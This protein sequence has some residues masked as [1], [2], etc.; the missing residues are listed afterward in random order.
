[1]TSDKN[2]LWSRQTDIGID[3]EIDIGINL[4]TDSSFQRLFAVGGGDVGYGGGRFGGGDEL[5]TEVTESRPESTKSLGSR[6]GTR[7]QRQKNDDGDPGKCERNI[8]ANLEQI[9]RRT[10]GWNRRSTTER[11]RNNSE[12]PKSEGQSNKDST[13]DEEQWLRSM[14]QNNEMEQKT[15]TEHRGTDSTIREEN[16]SFV[17]LCCDFNLLFYRFVY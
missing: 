15:S 11:T 10:I 1:M 17:L 13:S 7:F 5:V 6:R 4:S 9:S 2:A 14:T 3:I 12:R 16:H 8:G